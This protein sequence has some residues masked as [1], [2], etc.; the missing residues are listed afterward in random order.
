MSDL[1]MSRNKTHSSK[2]SPMTRPTGLRPRMIAVLT[3]PDLMTVSLFC[4]IG[5]LV[6]FN[7]ILR[8]PDFGAVMAQLGQFP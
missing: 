7:I 8:F 3:H 6:T 5:F 4:T 1:P 2:A